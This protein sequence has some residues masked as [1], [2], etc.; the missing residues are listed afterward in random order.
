MNHEWIHLLINYLVCHFMNS[1]RQLSLFFL[2]R[3]E[4]RDLLVFLMDLF[5]TDKLNS[6]PLFLFYQDLFA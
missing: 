1:Y 4:Y 5:T 3:I 6:I 2:C